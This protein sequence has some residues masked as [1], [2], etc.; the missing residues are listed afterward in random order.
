MTTTYCD[1]CMTAVYDEG[2]YEW[3]EQHAALEMASEA[4]SD[5]QCDRID[6]PDAGIKCDCLAHR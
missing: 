1:G 2:F 5:H 4:M 3:E 6:D